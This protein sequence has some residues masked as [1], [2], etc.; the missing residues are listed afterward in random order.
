[1]SAVGAAWRFL[2]RVPLGSAAA[3]APVMDRAPMWFPLVGA[4]VGG[5]AGAA[6]AGASW[7]AGPFVGAAVAVAVGALVTGAF[8]HD[9][10]A[11]IA[12]AFGGG[13]DVEQRL[14]ILKDSRHGTY[15]VVSLV[16]VLAVQVAALTALDRVEGATMLVVAHTVA[17]AAAVGLLRWAPRAPRPGLG[18][19]VASRLRTPYALVALATA[20]VLAAVALG[21]LVPWV[22]AAA[23]L[24]AAAT[25][26]LA[27]RKIGGINGDVLGAAEQVAETL[28]LVCGAAFVRHA[29]SWPWWR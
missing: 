28:V 18:V 3:D 2:T 12:D 21:A 22:L 26:V 6:F 14:A 16:C 10:L 27:R 20:V 8:H 9:G 11:D 29:G 1:M 13:W 4:V 15:G 17:R 23:A 25:A 24:G 19:D 5:I 7:L